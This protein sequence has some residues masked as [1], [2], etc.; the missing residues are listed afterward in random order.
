MQSSCF[1]Y[2]IKDDIS[3]AGKDKLDQVG[4]G[5]RGQMRVNWP[6]LQIDFTLAQKSIDY[7]PGRVLVIM[8]FAIF[9]LEFEALSTEYWGEINSK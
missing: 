9:T 5:G 4:I 8:H 2:L 6:F 1:E 3:N 7:K